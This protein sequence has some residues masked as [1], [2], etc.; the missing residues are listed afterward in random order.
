MPAPY[1]KVEI[2][3]DAE[4]LARR[5]AEEIVGLARSGRQRFA[6]CLSG[7]STPR[8]LYRLLAD[9]PYRDRLPWGRVHWFWGDERYVPWDNEESNYRMVREAMLER[10]PAPPENVHAIATAPTP[11]EA[12]HTYERELKT[13]YGAETFDP[14]SPLFD[15]TLLGL[16][17]DGHTASLFP[18]SP[19]L[20]ERQRWAAAVVGSRP[21]ARITLTYPALESGRRTI[22]LVA[23][24]EKAAI[25]ARALAGDR[26]LPAA[27]LRPR[28]ELCWLV[29][30]AARAGAS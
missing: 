17:E 23:G 15:L 12:A 22:F 10:A 28:G 20:E 21:E 3:A 9:A 8:R 5:A 24:E 7:G 30:A 11:A 26:E 1:A 14:A 6:I 29:D 4:A 13:F 2:V 16:G 19:V 18:G 27:R 25:L